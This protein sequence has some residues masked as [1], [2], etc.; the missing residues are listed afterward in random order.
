MYVLKEKAYTK[1]D[2]AC[3]N[4]ADVQDPCHRNFRKTFCPEPATFR[5]ITAHAQEAFHASGSLR[6]TPNIVS[7]SFSKISREH[8]THRHNVRYKQADIIQNLDMRAGR[9]EAVI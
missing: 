7:L 5:S 1:A 3:E 8:H 6:S 4:L 9:C 2:F